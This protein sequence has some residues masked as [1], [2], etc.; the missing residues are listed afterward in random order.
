ME[1]QRQHNRPWRGERRGQG[2]A[3]RKLKAEGRGIKLT[4]EG[5]HKGQWQHNEPCRACI[6][7][8]GHTYTN[9]ERHREGRGYKLIMVC[10]RE[11]ARAG[12][13]RTVDEGEGIGSGAAS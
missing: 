11:K 4:K 7:G 2:H 5:R 10:R 12:R 13:R 8:Q 1:V 3:H 9:N 6:R